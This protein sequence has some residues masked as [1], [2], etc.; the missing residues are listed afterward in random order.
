MFELRRRMSFLQKMD[1][2]R[3]F[4]CG[5]TGSLARMNV[6]AQKLNVFSCGKADS[7][8]ARS[9]APPSF[10]ESVRTTLKWGS[11]KLPNVAFFGPVGHLAV[12]ADH[13]QVGWVCLKRG[14]QIKLSLKP[15]G[16]FSPKL[17][18]NHKFTQY[19]SQTFYHLYFFPKQI[20]IHALKY[21]MTNQLY[22]FKIFMLF[23]IP[24]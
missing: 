22:V 14:I 2:L 5:K 18:P 13:G 15:V 24:S 6:L 10:P 11:I 12:F 23:N 20:D 17:N 19:E 3:F 16:Q 8:A 1:S 9:L 4:S 21:S 7:L